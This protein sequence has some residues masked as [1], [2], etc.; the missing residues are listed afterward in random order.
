MYFVGSLSQIYRRLFSV[1]RGSVV[2]WFLSFPNKGCFLGSFRRYRLGSVYQQQKTVKPG[3][4]NGWIKL[5]SDNFLQIEV[6]HQILWKER[7][8]AGTST[9]GLDSLCGWVLLLGSTFPGFPYFLIYQKN[10]FSS[11]VSKV[12]LPQLIK[13]R[14]VRVRSS[15]R[16]QWR[17]SCWPSRGIR[18]PSRQSGEVSFP[19]DRCDEIFRLSAQRL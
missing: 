12:I 19:R 16:N 17:Q 13:Q 9:M 7:S 5:D 4:L 11:G 10:V 14:W 1:G 6:I 2:E 8:Q 18:F 3:P 15:S